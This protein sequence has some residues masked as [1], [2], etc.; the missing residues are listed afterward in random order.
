MG[1]ELIITEKPSAANKIAFALSDSTPKKENIAGVPVYELTHNGKKIKVACAVGHLFT[2]A[3]KKK[4][5]AYPSFDVEWKATADVDK[6]AAYS[7]KYITAIKS[8][9][10]GADSFTVACD[11][12]IEGEVIGLNC[13]RFICNKKDA[14]RMKFSTLTKPDLVESYAEKQGT[15]DWG[16]AHAG[17]TRHI[18]DWIY[19]INLSRALTLALR[20][21]KI[22]KTLSSGRVQG[23]T[24]KLIVDRELEI[25]KFV[26]QKYWQIELLGVLNKKN[27][28]AFHEKDKF[29]DESECKKSFAKAKGH[30]GTVKKVDRSE[31]KQAP[32]TPFDL[33]TLQMESFKV[34]KYSPTMTLNLAQELYLAG[35][36]SYPRTSSQKLPA[37]I[38]YKKIFDALCR[39]DSN[40][41]KLYTILSKKKN[42]VP[43]EG[44]KEDPAHPAI[45]PTGTN[46]E[47]FSGTQRR[48]YDLIVKRFFATFGDFATRQTLTIN[49]DVNTEIFIA[50]G[51]TTKDPGWHVLYEP[52]SKQK[53]EELPNATEGDI[54][55]TKEL[56]KQDKQTE[57]PKR[58]TQASLI[59]E[60][61]KR[62][63]GTKS[64]RAQ[65]IDSLATRGYLDEKTIEATQLGI[66][67]IDVLS[68]YSPRI[69]DEELTR[70]FQDD[71]DKIREEKNNDG[72]KIIKKAEKELTE[73]LEDFKKK[74]K[75]IGE[76]LKDAYRESMTTEIGLC[77]SCKKGKLVVKSSR[78]TKQRFI[79]CDA[80]PDCK[81]IFPVPQK[82]SIKALDKMCEECKFPLIEI[83][84]KKKQ[85]VCF[86]PGCKSRKITDKAIAK[87]AEKITNGKTERKCPKCENGN[88]VVRNSVYGSFLGCSNYPKCR[89]IE[90]I[91]PQG[92]P[93]KEEIKEESKK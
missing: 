40:Y 50:K 81:T 57:P 55:K 78:K 79:A 85:E 71:M 44:T 66:K 32:P 53:E 54:V 11:Y 43:N 90:K 60:L 20:R 15:L 35:V 1:Y 87:I 76:N 47:R 61:E 80:Y 21:A 74:E 62:N 12:D 70:S 17:E 29:W 69:I 93:K 26:P 2:V 10:K 34:F 59:K 6:N 83:R 45:Y 39:N 27:I 88:L 51:T 52:Y 91:A 37:K 48:L 23:P 65:I 46:A 49:I 14:S 30:D 72:S 82:G 36:I 73:I 9:T 19:G 38:G 25:Q 92:E 64:T 8:L 28:S 84:N 13:I 5:F 24:L 31:F 89:H 41:A 33:T 18:L 56:V 67:T 75:N 77:P 63:L 86:N 16:Q 4:S 3:E 7:K 42:L 68:K 58:Y 22:Y